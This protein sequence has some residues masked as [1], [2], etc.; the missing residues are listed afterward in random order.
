M[1]GQVEPSF[2]EA[3]GLTG[4]LVLGVVV[5]G[6]TRVSWR[7]FEH[8]FAVVGRDPE[9]DLPLAAPELSRRH[10]YLQVVA[11]RIFCVDLHSR[12]GTHW[13]DEANLGNEDQ[14][15][16]AVR[17]GE[18]QI[19]PRN[20]DIRSPLLMAGAGSEPSSAGARSSRQPERPGI[21]LQ[22]VGGMG[23]PATWHASQTL[24]L[25]G[26]S[27]ACK[28]QLAGPSVGKIHASLVR[29]AAGVYV[30]DLL[31]PGGILVN[32]EPVR[33]ARLNERD[34][35]A[36][37]EHTIRV[38]AQCLRTSSSRPSPPP[39]A[40]LPLPTEQPPLPQPAEPVQAGVLDVLQ[41]IVA[42]QQEQMTL[43][44]A[45]LAEI[46]RWTVEQH[47]L[48]AEVDQQGQANRSGR[49]LRVV[50]GESRALARVSDATSRPATKVGAAPLPLAI[51]RNSL[52]EGTELSESAGKPGAD[53]FPTQVF[54]RLTKIQ[55]EGTNRW[56]R[57]R[58]TMLGK[59]A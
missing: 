36:V 11:G 37:G 3:C 30:V 56:Q 33:W 4:P 5:P 14:P 20:G 16:V 52:A 2:A 39:L 49:V 22:S 29:T 40:N 48:R 55:G 9:A 23:E 47:E 51:R 12:T 53:T 43:L 6:Q 1:V 21:S 13:S 35:L 58:E 8:P 19:R 44:R 50:A 41:S 24:T 57:L 15:E 10:A 59:E 38:R 34:E 27:A 25:I 31:G 42:L 32:G 28:V 18:Y 54:D 46:R 7:M 45:E 17:I 26:R